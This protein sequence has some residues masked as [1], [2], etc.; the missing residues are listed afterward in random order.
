MTRRL[1]LILPLVLALFVTRSF[2]V[3]QQHEPTHATSTA[4]TEHTTEHAAGE[5]HEEK[6]FLG[7][8][9]WIFQLINMVLFFGILIYLVK[10]PV[11]KAFA[12][13]RAAV[14]QQLSD[15]TDRRQKA[16]R[17]AADIQQRLSQLEGEAAAILDR[18]RQEGE[19][20]KAELLAAAEAESTKILAAARLE[21]DT[22][23]KAARQELT[24]YARHLSTQR[25]EELLKSA[26]NDNDRKRLFD[27]SVQSLAEVKS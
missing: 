24:D 2:A 21:V 18:A 19:K 20:Q 14:K 5:H 16:D 1:L 22:K 10:G 26:I 13:R 23:L 27:E 25:A 6:K 15:A 7:L 11:G 12:E 9:F 17:L 4:T 3:S 8:P